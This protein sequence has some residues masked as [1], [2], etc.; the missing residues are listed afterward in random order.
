ASP[1]FYTVI[2]EQTSRALSSRVNVESGIGNRWRSCMDE[3]MTGN[4]HRLKSASTIALAWN[5]GA[6][7]ATGRWHWSTLQD[8][9]DR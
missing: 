7:I 8:L 1:W 6:W 4:I 9:N 2:I 3:M 5:A